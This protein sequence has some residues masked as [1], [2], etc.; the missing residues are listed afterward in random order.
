MELWNGFS[1]AI[2]ARIIRTDTCWF[3]VGY[4]GNNGYGVIKRWG[5]P[6]IAHRLTYNAKYGAI[7]KGLELDHLCRNR[8]CVNPDHLEPVTHKVNNNRGVGISAQNARRTH[9]LKGHILFGNNLYIAKRLHGRT[10]RHCVPCQ[11]DAVR[12]HRAKHR[13]KT[14]IRRRAL[15]IRIEARG[16]IGYYKLTEV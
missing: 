8:C 16:H 1:A 14:K 11:R 13:I 7:P 5:R 12:R 4:V 9:C 10:E 3:W 6:Q 15:K 2:E